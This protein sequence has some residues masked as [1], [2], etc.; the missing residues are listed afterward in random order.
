MREGKTGRGAARLGLGN[1]GVRKCSEIDEAGIWM[2]KKGRLPE[3]LR[4]QSEQR[5]GSGGG[6]GREKGA[7]DKA[8][9]VRGGRIQAEVRK[10]RLMSLQ[11]YGL[12]Y[13][14]EDVRPGT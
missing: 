13:P 2:E 10:K 1:G 12:L 6:E 14:F 4:R 11:W 7:R 8:R 5:G 3:G 9:W